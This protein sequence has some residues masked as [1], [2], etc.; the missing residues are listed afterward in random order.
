MNHHRAQ[1]IGRDRLTVPVARRADALQSQD[2]VAPPLHEVLL[3]AKPLASGT[4]VMPGL[5]Q[6]SPSLL[7]SRGPGAARA[8]AQERERVSDR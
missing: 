5:L 3:D 4:A 6:A 1:A 7:F 8:W 2:H